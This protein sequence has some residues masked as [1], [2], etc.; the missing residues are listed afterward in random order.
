ML[1]IMLFLIQARTACLEEQ[2]SSPLGVFQVQAAAQT[3]VLPRI[4]SLVKVKTVSPVLLRLA[5]SH[6][7]PR[8]FQGHL[9]KDSQAEGGICMGKISR[10]GDT[11]SG[12]G[13]AL[14][15][16]QQRS[17]SG[18]AEQPK[19]SDIWIQNNEKRH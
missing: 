7:L 12:V 19:A 18:E 14:W 8:G 15:Q 4:G 3:H 5:S 17:R 1:R 13:Q 11:L 16:I 9:V 6:V 10:R 2:S